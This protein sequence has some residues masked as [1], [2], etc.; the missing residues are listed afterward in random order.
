MPGN[1]REQGSHAGVAELVDAPDLKSVGPKGP[2]RFE[3]GRPY[4]L[5]DYGGSRSFSRH[6]LSAELRIVGSLAPGWICPKLA[7]APPPHIACRAQ[8]AIPIGNTSAYACRECFAKFPP[9]LGLVIPDG[10]S[11]AGKKRQRAG[12]RPARGAYEKRSDAARGR[13]ADQGHAVGHLKG[14]KRLP[15]REHWPDLPDTAGAGS[16][17]EHRRG[18]P[19][20]SMGR[21]SGRAGRYRQYGPQTGDPSL[22]ARKAEMAD[23]RP[24]TLTARLGD[25]ETGAITQRHTGASASSMIRPR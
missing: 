15:R 25:Q 18:R 16:A 11:N 6:R 22:P 9:S 12:R 8:L 21:Q 2:C 10:N 7:G 13:S 17:D 14:G 1:E 20:A 19:F 23:K 5:T 4:Q 3:S 24:K